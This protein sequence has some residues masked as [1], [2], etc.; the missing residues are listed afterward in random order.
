MAEK[1]RD[2]MTRSDI[3]VLKKIYDR[4]II[5]GTNFFSAQPVTQKTF[6]LQNFITLMKTLI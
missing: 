3:V 2:C 4:G 1:T 5:R 6:H